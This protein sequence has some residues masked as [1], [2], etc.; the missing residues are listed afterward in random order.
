MR[1]LLIVGFGDIALRALP[2]L[3]IHF[4]VTAVVRPSRLA[5]VSP[6]PGV[7]IVP[8]DL[9]VPQSLE[10][11]AAEATHVLHCA[12]PPASGSHDVRTANLLVALASAARLERIVY[13]STSGVYGNCD[14]AW[15]DEDRPVNPGTDR[16]RRRVDAESRLQTWSTER[17]VRVIILRAP[18]IYAAERLPL[19]RLRNRTPV[20]RAEDDGYTNH[21]H[22]DDLARIAVCALTHPLARGI[23]NAADDTELRMGE[24]FDLLADRAGLARPPRIARA[25]AAAHIPAPLLSF[26]A[27]SRR[28]C[29]ERMKRELGVQLRYPTVF[30]GLPRTITS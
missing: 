5:Q 27:E 17:G 23:Y 8:A 4:Q 30:E 19:Q 1:R 26:M 24:W 29:N 12:P 28:L 22:A 16:A 13:I 2:E 25:D 11:I 15:V 3:C 14:G 21:I 18:G 10:N 6:R 9:D 7:Q 20:L